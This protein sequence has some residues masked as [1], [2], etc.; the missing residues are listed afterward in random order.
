MGEIRVV[1]SGK[2]YRQIFDAEVQLVRTLGETRRKSLHHGV[3]FDSGR[4]PIVRNLDTPVGQI[5]SHRQRTWMEGLLNDGLTEN[6]VLHRDAV[7]TAIKPKEVV[8]LN[9]AVREVKGLPDVVVPA[10]IG[11]GI[12]QLLADSKQ[13]KHETAVMNLEEE[14]ATISRD[15]EMRFTE[16][17][18]HLLQEMEESHQSIQEQWA[19]IENSTDISTLKFESLQELWEAIVKQSLQM[20][21][22][23]KQ[24]DRSYKEYEKERVKRITAAFKDCLKDLEK[25]AYLPSGDIYRFIDKEA[26]LVNQALLAN[27]RA[28][29]KLY[30][31]LMEADLMHEMSERKKR[32]VKVQELNAVKKNDIL[33]K[34]KGF[35]AK[36]WNA[37]LATEKDLLLKEQQKL[38]NKRIRRLEDIT[39]MKPLDFNKA[40][41]SAWYDSIRALNMEMDSLHIQYMGKLEAYYEKLYQEWMSEIDRCKEALVSLEV[42]TKEEAT[43]LMVSDFLPIVGDLQRLFENELST[44][45]KHMEILA[46]QMDFQCKEIYHFCKEATQLWEEHQVNLTDQ[47][48]QLKEQLDEC[49]KKHDKINQAREANLDLLIDQLRQRNTAVE[50]KSDL[51]KAI[52]LLDGIKKGYESFYKKQLKIV[53]NYPSMLEKE[54]DRF[55]AAISK[56]FVVIEIYKPHKL[57]I[58][59]DAPTAVASPH[60]ASEGVLEDIPQESDGNQSTSEEVTME[61]SIILDEYSEE[62]AELSSHIQGLSIESIN[63]REE[64]QES[65]NTSSRSER[66]SSIYVSQHLSEDA[67]EEAF[68][69]EE[70]SDGFNETNHGESVS[71]FEIFRTSRGNTYSVLYDKNSRESTNQSAFLTE[72]GKQNY[73]LDYMKHAFLPETILLNLK[74]RIR[75]NFFEHLEDWYDK[76]MENAKNI[77]VIKN[78]EFK[79]ELELRT[80]LHE[81]RGKRIK[82]DVHHARAAELR[83]HSEK[84]ERHCKGVDEVLEKLKTEFTALQSQHCKSILNFRNSIYSMEDILKNANKSDRLV[85]L[86]NSLHSNQDKYMVSV[87]KLLRDFQIKLDKSLGKLQDDNTRFITSFRL[88]ADGGNFTPQEIEMYHRRVEQ[89]TTSIAKTEG[90]IMVD[91]EV[92]EALSLEQS[93]GVIKEVED[94]FTRYTLDLIFIEKIKRF[95]T[96]TQTK[97]K[98]EVAVSNNHTL[99]INSHLEQFERKIDACA[100]PN[101]DKGVVSPE[102]LYHFS[103]IIR[104]LMEKRAIYLNCLVD[105][106][107]TKIPLQGPI[108][109]ATRVEFQ[110]QENKIYESLLQPT[111]KGR[112]AIEDVAVG[113][114]KEI[115]QAHK[116]EG[117]LETEP[118]TADDQSA[119]R[120]SE[121]SD[122]SGSQ[123]VRSQGVS[124]RGQKTASTLPS[125]VKYSKPNRFDSKYQV[126]GETVEES[127]HFK[128][129]VRY[130]LWENTNALLAVAEDYYKKKDRQPVYRPEYLKDTFEQCAEELTQKMLSYQAQANAYHSS[131]LQEFREQLKVFEELV[132]SVPHFLIE[133][134]LK[135]HMDFTKRALAEKRSTFSKKLQQL[136]NAKTEN[137]H[138]LRPILGHPNNLEMLESLCKQEEERQDAEAA[139][140]KNNAEDQK[141]CMLEHAKAFVSALSSLS[142][143]LLLEFDNFLIVDN[144]QIAQPEV[145]SET[146][147]SFQQKGTEAPLQEEEND[148]AIEIHRESRIWPGIPAN[149]LS[150]ICIQSISKETASTATL[151]METASVTTAKTVLADLATV[152]ARDS[153]YAAAARLWGPA[154]P[155]QHVPVDDLP[156]RS[157]SWVGKTVV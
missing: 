51:K 31:N 36:D 136:E 25:I 48:H 70:R 98:T 121:I 17:A 37:G 6:P 42:C 76:A 19:K 130:I 65:R 1:P 87:N 146:T 10:K 157:L 147:T 94:K 52:C 144:V 113:I 151:S 154:F 23:I 44:V 150:Q 75:L 81:P 155:L 97:I 152:E 43:Q 69:P 123:N 84:V 61:Q 22:L 103:K 7:L 124:S 105:P 115:L 90:T 91:L 122:A 4:I 62:G 117:L 79:S 35:L 125:A 40:S 116:S 120:G 126:F 78:K 34:F 112:N 58:I 96:N 110:T 8:E 137:K 138:R 114:I 53:N 9:N 3:P 128:G 88:F 127:D 28:M 71:K 119:A 29:N 156:T 83:L 89:T 72:V 132:S 57:K 74:Q 26:M 143:Q 102:E 131:C 118:E 134:V 63:K 100:R 141:Q 101:P 20:R 68:S 85:I 45:D 133:D 15:L 148:S 73:L 41:L 109:T 139:E 104:D 106:A 145:A 107:L 39:D 55:S 24:L 14:L 21:E 54:L 108:A 93:T 140:I 5:F 77:A 11:S 33:Q 49:R 12:I 13:Q 67:S 27:H 153:A 47:K 99:N 46:Q 66:E 64:L 111:R 92:M 18:E 129:I 86:L 59:I 16:A 149:E 95:L 135:Q 60:E 80:H 50:L 38:N 2:V 32:N 56:Y 30:V 142:E 82:M